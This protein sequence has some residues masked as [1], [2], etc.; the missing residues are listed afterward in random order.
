MIKIKGRK[1]IIIQGIKIIIGK[2]KMYNKIIKNI[3]SFMFPPWAEY[4]LSKT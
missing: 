1:M 2:M 3:E 4:Y